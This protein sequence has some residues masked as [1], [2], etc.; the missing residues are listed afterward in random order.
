MVMIT[1]SGQGSRLRAAVDR[2]HAAQLAALGAPEACH[3]GGSDAC[4]SLRRLLEDAGEMGSLLARLGRADVEAAL[5]VDAR[6]RLVNLAVASANTLAELVGLAFELETARGEADERGGMPAVEA[7]RAM[8]HGGSCGSAAGLPGSNGASAPAKPTTS[9]RAV[10]DAHRLL[11]DQLRRLMQHGQRQETWRTARPGE[12]WRGLLAQVAG[13]LPLV[14]A[15][16]A[17]G[18]SETEAKEMS[19]LSADAANYAAF[20]RCYPRT[21]T[22]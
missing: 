22:A 2:L 4:G 12:L 16:E 17:G 21:P 3:A 9:M 8:H 7:P 14:A 13:L 15:Q 20:I 5:A 18:L 11:V 1:E 6:R 19:R 10:T